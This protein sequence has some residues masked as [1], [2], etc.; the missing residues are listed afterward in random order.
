MLA[1]LTWIVGVTCITHAVHNALK[2]SAATFIHDPACMRS[3]YI[4][5]A[6]LRN[7]FDQLARHARP[8]IGDRIVLEDWNFPHLE[9]L[10]TILVRDEELRKAL[11]DL[12]LR[13]SNGYLRIARKYFEQPAEAI[14]IV[15]TVF[16]KLWQFRDFCDSRWCTLGPS[17]RTLVACFI[18]G[19]PEYVHYIMTIPV[20]VSKYFISGFEKHCTLQVK[21][22]L[23]IVAVNSHLADD[24]LFLL[25]QDDRLLMQIEK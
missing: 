11:I 17:A 5:I 21:R 20:G 16:L 13:F 14:G 22:M 2:W 9:Q 4:C 3:A 6:S 12:Q 23:A 24:V 8:W 18:L 15:I 10:W 25:L 19:L 1:M 7:S